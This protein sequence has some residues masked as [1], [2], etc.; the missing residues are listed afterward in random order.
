MN[1][2]SLDYSQAG[3]SGANRLASKPGLRRWLT[4]RS[5]YRSLRGYVLAGLLFTLSIVTLGSIR[6]GQLHTDN[7]YLRA[8]HDAHRLRYDSLLAAKLEADRRLHLL[9]KQQ[10]LSNS[11]LTAP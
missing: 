4:G 7:T 6:L 10:R 3:R 5:R 9:L 11:I 1:R 2:F 8:Q